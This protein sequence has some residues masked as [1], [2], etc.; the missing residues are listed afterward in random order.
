MSSIQVCKNAWHGEEAAGVACPGA[1]MARG[2]CRHIRRSPLN[3]LR[4]GLPL[5]SRDDIREREADFPDAAND[6]R[7]Y[8]IGVV[9]FAADARLYAKG[10][11]PFDQRAAG[12]SRPW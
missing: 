2:I 10:A 8:L 9:Q 6:L 11:R 12:K 1:A 4:C 5:S 3:G 7:Q